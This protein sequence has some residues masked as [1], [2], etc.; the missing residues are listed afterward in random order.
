MVR[1]PNTG[2]RVYFSIR[3]CPLGPLTE[4]YFTLWKEVE[5]TIRLHYGRCHVNHNYCLVKKKKLPDLSQSEKKC[6][7]LFFCGYS[8]TEVGY[9]FDENHVPVCGAERKTLTTDLPSQ[10]LRKLE[11]Q[12]KNNCCQ[13]D[14]ESLILHP[15]AD[16]S[17]ASPLL[18]IRKKIDER[19][20]AC[21]IMKTSPLL[22]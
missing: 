9:K 11:S 8:Q 13:L 14:P 20:V 6:L 3:R 7:F 16:L 15:P 5:E 1:P 10:C 17:A 19:T 4:L 22:N 2:T 18:L 21:L 12:K